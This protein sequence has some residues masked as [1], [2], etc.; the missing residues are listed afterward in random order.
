M[1][2]ITSFRDQIYISL[3]H[4]PTINNC[5]Q[6]YDCL[7]LL[8]VHRT[9]AYIR[10]YIIIK[11]HYDTTFRRFAKSFKFISKNAAFVFDY[12]SLIYPSLTLNL[13][14]LLYTLVRLSHFVNLDFVAV[15]FFSSFFSSSIN[16][17]IRDLQLCLAIS[18]ITFSTWNLRGGKLNFLI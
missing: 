11:F 14:T 7:L 3:M 16:C 18:D 9:I 15:F 13:H 4:V 8:D 5:I 10:I 2:Q 6:V 17:N 1:N 12:F